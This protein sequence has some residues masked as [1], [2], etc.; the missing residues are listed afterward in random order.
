[1]VWKIESLR[2]IFFAL[3]FLAA[4]IVG[5]VSLA[6]LQYDADVRTSTR[7]DR[8]V[9]DGAGAARR[10]GRPRRTAPA[11][12]PAA[13]PG[14]AP[15][16]PLPRLAALVV[17][18]RRRLRVRLGALARRGHRGPRPDR[19][20]PGDRRPRRAGHPVARHPAPGPVGRVLD[21]RPVRPAGPGRSCRSSAGSATASG[22]RW[23]IR[24]WC[25]CSSS[26]ASS[27]PRPGRSST[28][29]RA[30]LGRRRGPGRDAA[31][32]PGRSPE[33][34]AA[35]ASLDVALRRRAGALRRRPRGGGGRDRG[36]ARH[37]RRRQVDAAQGHLGRDRGRA[38]ARSI[39][40]G[41]DIT[42]APPGRD[43]RRWAS[44]RCPAGKGVFPG[45]HRRREPAGRRLDGPR[46]T[47]PPWPSAGRE[48]HELFPVLGRAPRRP[49]RRPVGR[50]AADAGAV[51]GVPHPAPAARDRRAV[52][53]PGPRRRRPAA[54]RRAGPARPGHDDHAGRAVGERGP[55]GGRPGLLHGEGRGPLR[56]PHRR[57]ARPARRPALGLPRG[58][59]QG[60]G[61]G[62]R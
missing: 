19:R 44:P 61:L 45:A 25:R 33:A 10:A 32:A 1:M 38:G 26:A 5:F 30:G 36:P 40:D 3:P 43:R 9:V 55:D 27:S 23:G 31:G 20:R 16:V 60:P 13:R 42:H 34:A 28:R 29:H 24:S 62:G 57:A 7:S 8:A 12:R 51:D 35:C 56:R 37:Q 22:F 15:G 49:R 52:A 47:R 50:P 59:Q 39:F 21:R 6:S 18:R 2:R 54:R 41:R 14:P 48:V 4:S 17:G 53:R 11:G 46:A 58:R